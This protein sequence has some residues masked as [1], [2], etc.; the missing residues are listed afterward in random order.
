MKLMNTPTRL[1]P[2]SRYIRT[3]CCLLAV[4]QVG[5]AELAPRP[6][7]SLL[8]VV[9]SGIANSLIRSYDPDD[10]ESRFN[11]TY[12]QNYTSGLAVSPDGFL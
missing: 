1:R 7:I 4:A 5:A 6:D 11:R 3:A 10:R 12:V 9:T 8:P 2:P